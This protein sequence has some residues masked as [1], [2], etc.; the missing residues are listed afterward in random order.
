LRIRLNRARTSSYFIDLNYNYMPNISGK[1]EKKSLAKALSFKIKFTFNKYYQYSKI[2]KGDRRW[3][4]MFVVARFPL[5]RAMGTLF[6]QRLQGEKQSSAYVQLKT[7]F[8]FSQKLVTT[9]PLSQQARSPVG[10]VNL[11]QRS[12]QAPSI[13]GAIRLREA[14]SADYMRT[15]PLCPHGGVISDSLQIKL[16]KDRQKILSDVEEAGSMFQDVDVDLVSSSVEQNGYFL[17]LNLP[18]NIARE[19]LEFAYATDII[20]DCNPHRKFKY[21]DREQ[22]ADKYNTNILVGNYATKDLQKCTAFNKLQTDSKL[23]A[24]AGKYLNSSPIL[25]RSQMNWTFIGDEQAYYDK[26]DIGTPTVLFHYDL[27]D[28]RTIKFF[29]Y[30]TDVNSSSGSHR[31]VAGSH[32]RRKLMH[33]IFRGQSDRQI[34]EYYGAE[35]I[36]DICGSAGFGF[37][38]DPFCFHRGSPPVISPR[39]IIQLEF[40]LNDYQ[41]WN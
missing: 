2:V 38:E 11:D 17:G 33:Y 14:K 24:I 30:L 1:P 35:N 23:I 13:A 28:Y 31:C 4:L 26:G 19:I 41:M 18:R 32:H 12:E 39:L 29:F 3:L 37:A 5:G 25:V 15:S 7:L 16:K 21:A 10:S 27:D 20:A 8:G 40:A 22:V 9:V 36:I 34:E 6:Y